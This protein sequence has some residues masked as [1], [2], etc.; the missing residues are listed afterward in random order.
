[1]LLSVLLRLCSDSE[2]QVLI[3]QY[4]DVAP[5]LPGLPPLLPCEGSC[6]MAMP[7]IDQRAEYNHV[8]SASATTHDDV[9]GWEDEQEPQGRASQER[10][11]ECDMCQHTV[12]ISRKRD[13][14]YVP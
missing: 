9:D 12:V 10:E 1:M 4:Y 2:R 14:Q 5:S 11:R 6:S 7:S 13:W 3:R 8:F